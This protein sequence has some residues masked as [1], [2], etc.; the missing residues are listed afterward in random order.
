MDGAGAARG[1]RIIPPVYFLLAIGIMTV[2]DHLVP[3]MRLVAPPLSHLG[4]LPIGLGFLVAFAALDRFRRAGTT[5]KPFQESSALVT[6]GL[7]ALSRN[8]MYVC[9]TLA[10]IGVVILFGTLTPATVLPAF[11]WVIN[12]RVIPI[13]EAMLENAFGDAYRDYKTRVRRWL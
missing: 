5:H 9:L 13:E 4:W 7:Y 10:L 6:D 8:P 2:L 3:G 12:T 1:L 11:V